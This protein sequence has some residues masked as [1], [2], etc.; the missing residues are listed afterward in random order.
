M[1]FAAWVIGCVNMTASLAFSAIG[2]HSKSLDEVARI[3]MHRAVN[4]HQLASVG[5]LVLSQL[6]TPYVPLGILSVATL[7]FPGVVYYQTLSQQKMWLGRFVP[8]GGML[9]MV[10]WLSLC[11]YFPKK[12]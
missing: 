9:H 4:V 12:D 5:F 11:L 1:D 10:F 6:D 2:H 8:T 3:S 7:L